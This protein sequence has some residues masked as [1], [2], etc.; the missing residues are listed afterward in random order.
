V[1]SATRFTRSGWRWEGSAEDLLRCIFRAAG[2]GGHHMSTTP[3]ETTPT[4]AQGT[5]GKHRRRHGATHTAGVGEETPRGG[6]ITVGEN[7]GL[8]L[9]ETG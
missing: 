2:A 1:N 8:P 5:D 4:H 6:S 3:S 7:R 9:S